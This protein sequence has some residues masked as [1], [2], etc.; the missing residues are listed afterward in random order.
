MM[1]AIKMANIKPI[2]CMH[3]FLSVLLIHTTNNRTNK[4]IL[5]YLIQLNGS[6]QCRDDDEY[7]GFY[8]TNTLSFEFSS[9]GLSKFKS[10]SFDIKLDCQAFKTSYSTETAPRIYLSL[11]QNSEPIININN[12]EEWMF[13]A[14]KKKQSIDNF[15]PEKQQIEHRNLYFDALINATNDDLN[16]QDILDEY[17]ELFGTNITSFPQLS[18]NWY[19]HSVSVIC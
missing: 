7:I 5:V 18:P 14:D 4:V 1:M 10:I 6:Q 3:L 2:Y 16:D 17:N 15:L 12:M 9:Y 19:V 8:S 13:I 11:H